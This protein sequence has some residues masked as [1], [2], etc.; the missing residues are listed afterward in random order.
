MSYFTMSSIFCIPPI[1]F[2]T[3]Q[4]LYGVSYTLLGTVLEIFTIRHFLKNTSTGVAGG[5]V[6]YS[7]CIPVPARAASKSTRISSEGAFV[8]RETTAMQ[9]LEKMKAG[10]SS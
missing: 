3:F 8:S 1:L 9:M 4:Q 6:F 10:N 7:Y 2:V 5:C